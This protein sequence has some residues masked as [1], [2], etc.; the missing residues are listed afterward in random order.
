MS[1]AAQARL[2]RLPPAVSPKRMGPANE[3]PVR[4]ST[5]RQVAGRGFRRGVLK[6]RRRRKTHGERSSSEKGPVMK[7]NF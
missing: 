4:Q 2:P 6:V 7:G 5:S 3:P 1:K